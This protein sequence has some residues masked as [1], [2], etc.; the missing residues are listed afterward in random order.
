MGLPMEQGKGW[1]KMVNT[2]AKPFYVVSH[3]MK[4]QLGT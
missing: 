2:N 4:L 3:N 1:I